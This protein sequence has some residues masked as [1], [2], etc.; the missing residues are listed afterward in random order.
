MLAIT[1]GIN[2]WYV[3]NVT[4]MRYGKY[5]LFAE[6]ELLGENPYNGDA[7]VFLSKDRQTLKIIRFKNHKRFLYDNTYEKGYKF[8]QPVFDGN[9]IIYELDFKYLAALLECPVVKTISI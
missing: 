2:L 4:N 8:L 1:G 9:T 6:V 5:R 3:S 7:Y